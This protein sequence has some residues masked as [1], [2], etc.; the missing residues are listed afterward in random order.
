MDRRSAL[1]IKLHSKG[2]FLDPVTICSMFIKQEKKGK[3]IQGSIEMNGD[4][5]EY[6]FVKDGETIHDIVGEYTK[7]NYKGEIHYTLNEKKSSNFN[8]D[9][10]KLFEELPNRDKLIKSV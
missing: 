2:K 10:R 6:Y 4:E 1:K 8:E 3:I 7:L 5:M 9:S